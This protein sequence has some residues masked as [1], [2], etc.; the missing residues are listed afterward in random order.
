M[1][2]L[3]LGVAVVASLT[4]LTACSADEAEDTVETAAAVATDAATEA[5][6]AASEATGE[7]TV[8]L[9]SVGSAEN[10]ESFDITLTTEDGEEVTTL[11]AGDYSIQVSDPAATHNFHLMGGSVDETTSVPDLEEVVFEVTLEA[12]EY[13]YKCDPHPPMTKTFTVT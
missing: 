13:T 11:P 5:T 1:K 12:G 9:G 7:T 4:L 6:D 3:V 2:R 10:P 8:L